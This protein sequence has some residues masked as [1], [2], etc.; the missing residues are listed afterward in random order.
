MSL[1]QIIKQNLFYVPISISFQ[2]LFLTN[3]NQGK[4]RFIALLWS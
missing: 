3:I 2:T 4:Y 1:N